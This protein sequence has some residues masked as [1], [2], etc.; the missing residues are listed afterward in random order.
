M[1]TTENIA[2]IKYNFIHDF[3]NLNDRDKVNKI[4]IYYRMIM[5]DDSTLQKQSKLM[6]LYGALSG[7]EGEQ[8]QNAIAQARNQDREYSRKIVSFD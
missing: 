5:S 4:I 8:M 6:S 1:A 2:E 7:E 3:I